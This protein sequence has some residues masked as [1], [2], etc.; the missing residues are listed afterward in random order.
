[1]S[2]SPTRYTAMTLIRRLLP[3]ILILLVSVCAHSQEAAAVDSLRKAM[4]KAVTLEQKFPLMEELSRVLMNVSPKQS[5]EMGSQL[6]TLAEESRDRKYMF[7]AYLSNGT[8][9]SYMASQKV[10]SDKALGFY[11]KAL[12]LARQNRLTEET[13]IAQQHQALF[14]LMI[15]DKEKAFAYITQAS[16][17]TATLPNDSL[18][19]ESFN[20]FGQVYQAK[21]E[22]IMALRS[23]LNGLRLAEDIK[24]PALIRNC[25]IYLSDFYSDI[26]DYDKSIDYMT[27]AF[28]KLD[29]INEKNVPYQKV[30][31]TNNL[32][33]LFAKKK[34]YDIAISYFERSIRMADSLKFST[35]KIPGY[36]SLL[37]QYLRIDEPQKALNY[38]NSKEG[39]E[40]K[41]Y[42]TNFGMAPVIDQAYGVVYTGLGR[43]DSAGILLEKARPMF[44]NSGNEYNKVG[45]IAQLATYY[46]KS[47]NYKMAIEQY[48][49]VKELS[50]RN[51][52]LENVEKAA[53]Y[54]DTLY[55]KTGNLQES[56]KYNALYYQYKDSIK[57]LKRENEMRKEEAD[58]EQQ[59]LLKSQKEAE[60]LKKR[61]NNIQ[62]LAIVIGIISLFLSLVVLGMFKVSAGVIKAIGFFVF[63]MFFEFIFLIFKKNIYEFTKGEPWKDLAFMIG[64]AAILVPLHHWL[65]HKVLHYLT[66]HNRLTAAG[67]Q[68]RR[69]IFGRGDQ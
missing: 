32:G 13:A 34:N 46:N 50:E 22:N 28:K 2:P 44:E 60:E 57:T 45:F 16:S 47:G 52:W 5:D 12:E 20:I 18:R 29:Q 17:L 10:Y 69:R 40:L 33:N 55:R 65:E 38:L 41:K 3:V 1:M 24:N 36:I 23:Y 7:K 54:L 48:L 67:H 66:S 68:I 53:K 31:Y 9:C 4:E 39:D 51:G 58:D 21:N 42:L 64:L 6:I 19:A 43:F 63:L 56:G 25:Y 35:L 11:N 62:Y 14:Y 61:R 49:Q 37:N 8:R 26:E 30:I 27:L 15:P 59:R